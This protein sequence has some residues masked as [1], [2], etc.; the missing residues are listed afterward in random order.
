MRWIVLVLISSW[1]LGCLGGESPSTAE[2]RFFEG[3]WE[4]SQ[5]PAKGSLTYLSSERLEGR[6]IVNRSGQDSV[7]SDI[8]YRYTVKPESSFIVME[9]DSVV[10]SAFP[11]GEGGPYYMYYKASGDSILMGASQPP[12]LEFACDVGDC[13]D[14]VLYGDWKEISVGDLQIAIHADGS[15]SYYGRNFE[16][17]IENDFFIYHAPGDER[18][19]SAFYYRLAQGKLRLWRAK[20]DCSD[21]D[22]SVDNFNYYHRVD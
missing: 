22:C 9:L 18:S 4:Y 15:G 21:T 17:I 6:L 11:V 8:I 7:L 12:M 16:F 13:K 1:I 19:G 10:S 3:T 2:T 20:Y 14:G 5:G